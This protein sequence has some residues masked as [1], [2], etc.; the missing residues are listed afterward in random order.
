[1]PTANRRECPVRRRS[2]AA[3]K[4]AALQI[5]GREFFQE[6]GQSDAN[7]LDGVWVVRVGQRPSFLKKVGACVTGISFRAIVVRGRMQHIQR[8]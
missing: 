7:R 6:L 8:L 4:L 1:M 2:V 5:A 3:A